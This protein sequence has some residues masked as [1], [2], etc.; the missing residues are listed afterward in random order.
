MRTSRI[1]AGVA[2]VALIGSATVALTAMPA[3]AHHVAPTTITLTTT[4]TNTAYGD[5]LSFSGDTS[6]TDGSTSYVSDGTVTLMTLEAGSSTW[7][8]VAEDTSPSSLYFSGVKAKKNAQF[9]A[10]YSGWTEPAPS[11]YSHSYAAS[12]SAPVAVTVHRVAKSLRTKNLTVLGKIVPDFKN[13]KVQIRKVVGKKAKKWKTVKTNKKGA[14]KFTAPRVNKFRFVLVVPGDAKY[15]GWV[16][17][18]Y[19]VRIY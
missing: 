11:N 3:Q 9:K 14:F 6:V 10:V 7:V 4:T 1:A 8:P 12:E 16:S 15:A 2:S 13:K 5:T 18:P 17:D 19:I